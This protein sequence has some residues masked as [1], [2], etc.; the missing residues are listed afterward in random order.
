MMIGVLH[1]ARIP[2]GSPFPYDV[3]VAHDLHFKLAYSASK[4]IVQRIDVVRELSFVFLSDL[5]VGVHCV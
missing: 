1:Q 4:G 5:L 2:L 3:A